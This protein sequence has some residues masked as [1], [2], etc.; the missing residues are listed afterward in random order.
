MYRKSN[1]AV[2]I[3][4]DLPNGIYCLGGYSGNGKTRL[5]KL[6]RVIQKRE[7]ETS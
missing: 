7:I 3:G 6:L 5:A 4:V 2:N 1:L